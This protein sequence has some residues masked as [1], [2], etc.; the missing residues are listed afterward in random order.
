MH[1]SRLNSIGCLL[2]LV[3][4]AGLTALPTLAQPGAAA[5]DASLKAFRSAV[6]RDQSVD[7]EPLLERMRH[8]LP[9]GDA[10]RK[11]QYEASY[12][13]SDHFLARIPDGLA[14]SRRALANARALGDAPTIAAAL[15]CV[16]SFRQLAE[17]PRHGIPEIQEALKI[18]KTLPSTELLGDVHF[19]SGI[20]ASVM[21]R[22][23]ASLVDFQLA[24]ESYR[25]AGF[26][27]EIPALFD[28]IAVTC[29]RMGYLERAERMFRQ[30]AAQAQRDGDHTRWEMNMLQIGYVYNQ[31]GDATNAI[32]TLREAFAKARPETPVMWRNAANLALA[33]AL[34][35][36]GKVNEGLH[37][38]DLADA[39]FANLGD[40]SNAGVQHFVRAMAHQRRDEPRAALAQLRQA[41]SYFERDGNLRYQSLA[42]QVRSEVLEE[43]GDATAAM[44]S[45]IRH[46]RLEQQLHEQL[47][48]DQGLLL[49]A[50]DQLREH[51]IE[52]L[53]L[54]AERDARTAQLTASD[55]IRRWQWLTMLLGSLAALLAGLMLAQRL[56]KSSALARLAMVDPTTDVASRLG[57]QDAGQRAL[58]QARRDAAPLSVMMIDADH[59]KAINDS[60]GHRVGDQV[61]RHIAMA[62]QQSLRK[63]DHIGRFGGEEFLAVCADLDTDAAMRIAQR[64][65]GA[66][67][68]IPG[69]IGIDG[70]TGLS[71]SIGVA[72]TQD[73]NED[74]GD[75]VE[76]A[77]RALYRAKQNG[78][79]RAE[80]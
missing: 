17:G 47:R 46:L 52:N 1:A 2:I 56:R 59:F 48:L 28:R 12:C 74:W 29:R 33:E 5:F 9:P 40:T 70:L 44:R 32:A 26:G 4:L 73:G 14:Y 41:D 53:R 58:Q 15:L 7:I 22:Q 19:F 31:T 16:S 57:V 76:R 79:N 37:V 67:N 20:V 39:G 77:D 55:N 62:C 30:A 61:L 21:G 35:R 71:V 27:G 49:E 50:Q 66:V 63:D 36:D 43:L 68:A 34:I 60:L 8:T 24:R 3:A 42:E 38:L 64:I 18:A 25:A 11:G 54:R 23:A 13:N 10:L 45:T 6:Y 78:R 80:R 72:T 69:Q 75:L 51:Q 65:L